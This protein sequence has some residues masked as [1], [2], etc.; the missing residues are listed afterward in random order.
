MGVKHLLWG[1]AGSQERQGYGGA[2]KCRG[3]WGTRGGR[4]VRDRTYGCH[5]PTAVTSL[6]SKV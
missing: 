3:A 2:T 6:H 1:G 5:D 4:R